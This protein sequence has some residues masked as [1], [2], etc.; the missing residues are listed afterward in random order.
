MATTTEIPAA[1]PCAMAPAA[2]PLVSSH[3]FTSG[4]ESTSSECQTVGTG[5][6]NTPPQKPDRISIIATRSGMI[7]PNTSAQL[8]PFFRVT[9]AT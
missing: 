8:Q 6:K 1:I 4:T 7:T 2:R 5:S 3:Q 9:R